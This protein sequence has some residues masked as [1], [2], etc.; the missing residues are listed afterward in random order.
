MKNIFFVF[1]SVILS[2]TIFAQQPAKGSDAKE[3]VLPDVKGKSIN[4]S[5]LKGK[6]VLVDF[7]ASWCGPCRRSMPSL[8]EIYAKYHDKGLEVYG[9]S[10]DV[11]K[12]DWLKAIKEDN[13]TW[14]HVI[15]IKGDVAEKWGVEYIPDTFLIDKNG[16]IVAINP[17]HDALDGMIAKLL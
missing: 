9:I 4:L 8:R 1:V 11:N 2:M 17:S 12:A 13:T 7:W 10:L 14:L 15:D 3:I 6:V 16:K 5:S